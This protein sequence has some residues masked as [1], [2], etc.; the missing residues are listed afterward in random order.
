MTALP[1]QP[2]SGCAASAERRA[3]VLAASAPPAERWL[4]IERR[5]PWPR[6]ALTAF[7]RPPEDRDLQSGVRDQLNGRGGAA[8]IRADDLAAEVSRF[9][10]ALRCRPALIRR[11]GRIDQAVPRRWAMVDSRLGH[12]SVRWGELPTDEHLL[13]VLA[14]RDQGAPSDEPIYLICTHG[15]HDPCCAMRG[16]PTAAALAAIHPDRT[17]ECSHVGGDRFAANVVLLP[18]GLFYGHVPPTRAAEVV[19][20]YDEGLVVPDLLRG[21]GALP[22]QV[23]A[24]QHFARAARRSLKVDSL[25]P[26]A[27]QELARDRW[28]VRLDDEGQE[29]VVVVAARLVAIDGSMTCASSPPGRVRQFDLVGLVEV[30]RGDGAFYSSV[31][32]RSSWWVP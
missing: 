8:D 14:G 11:Y 22:P 27:V 28:R 31:T 15:R 24:A 10:A 20:R 13:E 32:K 6:D 3:D 23:Q 9:C 25:R 16:R 29:V 4:L 19:S 30:Q 2:D 5:G 26:T 7:R 1:Y 21:V 18:H 17:W 12:E